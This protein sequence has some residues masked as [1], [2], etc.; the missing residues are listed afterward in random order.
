MG[1]VPPAPLGAHVPWAA[2]PP[3][4]LDRPDTYSGF[5]NDLKKSLSTL[6][7]E[8]RDR[9]LQSESAINILGG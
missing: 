1:H 5:R 8:L 9:S 4:G 6:V 2:G 7:M 3:A